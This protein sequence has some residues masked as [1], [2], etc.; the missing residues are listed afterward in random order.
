VRFILIAGISNILFWLALFLVL[1]VIEAVTLGLFTIWFALGALFGFFGALAGLSFLGQV[2]LFLLSAIMLMIYTRPV[3]AKYLNNK[4]KRTNAD[5]LVG[6]QGIVIEEIDAVNGTG[7]VKVL[8]Q[9]WSARP[10]NGEKI[11]V[12][13]KVE[14]QAISGVKLIV[15]KI[16]EQKMVKEE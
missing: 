8:G 13:A 4:I 3:A 14:V 1:A 15:Q 16:V 11:A 5:R 7:Q 6:E 2:I 12:A 9:I 10:F